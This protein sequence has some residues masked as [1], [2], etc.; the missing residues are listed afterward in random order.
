MG[1]TTNDKSKDVQNL[2]S[3]I[4]SND[5]EKQN[6]DNK[7]SKSYNGHWNL[8]TSIIIAII[9]F[10]VTIGTTQ[11]QINN[12]QKENRENNIFQIATNID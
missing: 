10:F 5:D 12:S 9:G 3:K 7:P 2:K 8:I 1:Q 4:S 11:I 6:K